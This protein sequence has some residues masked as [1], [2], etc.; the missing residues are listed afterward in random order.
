MND[1]ED[2]R[3]FA[4]AAN[5]RAWELLADA[6]RDDAAKREMVDAAHASLWHWR[7]AGTVVHEQRGEWLVSHV[8]AVLGHGDAALAHAQW[9]WALTEEGALTGFDHAYA[10]EA[11]ARALAARGDAD[12]AASWRDRATTSA[13]NVTDEED[14]AILE[15]D[16]AAGPWF[17]VPLP[18]EPA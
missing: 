14:R 8:Y 10:C 6:S 9:C 2:H 18:P 15:A 16:L 4:A 5:N 13:S 7:Y 17:D 11:M 3:T 12:D 1:P